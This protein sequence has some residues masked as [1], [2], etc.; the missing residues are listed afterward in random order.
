M[1][2]GFAV[3]AFVA[4]LGPALAG[5]AGVAGYV[6]PDGRLMVVLERDEGFGQVETVGVVAEPGTG[7]A[8]RI[9]RS[10]GDTPLRFLGWREARVAELERAAEGGEGVY[11]LR[12]ACG[13]EACTLERAGGR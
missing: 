11:R 8:R 3:L 5:V 7:R 6:S 12:L 10:V 13:E 2:F 9:F 1:G 4:V